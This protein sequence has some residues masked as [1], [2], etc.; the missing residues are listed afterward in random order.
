MSF[1]SIAYSLRGSNIGCGYLTNVQPAVKLTKN[2]RAKAVNRT[3]RFQRGR[4][5]SGKVRADASAGAEWTWELQ[6]E[7]DNRE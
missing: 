7:S 2:N 3:S 6:T 5:E 4:R 1:N